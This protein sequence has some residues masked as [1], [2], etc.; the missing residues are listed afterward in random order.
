MT[1][2]FMAGFE[3]STQRRRDGVRLDLLAATAHDRFAAQ[4][5]RRCA[6][7]GIRR[8][9]DGL[10]W[11]LIEV[12]A[13]RYDWSSWA[14]MVEAADVAAGQAVSDPASLVAP[15]VVSGSLYL[16]MTAIS[17]LKPWGPT[18]RGRRMGGRRVPAPAGEGR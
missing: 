2:L 17:V 14:P 18:R 10:R 13:G 1:D 15:P 9:R 7:L 4:D 11:H 16:F 5:Y 6:A 3:C 12:A 8:V